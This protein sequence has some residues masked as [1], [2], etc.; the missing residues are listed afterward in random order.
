MLFTL[1]FNFKNIHTQPAVVC[2]SQKLVLLQYMSIM[3]IL[4]NV[5]HS[6][7]NLPSLSQSGAHVAR[8]GSGSLTGDGM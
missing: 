4:N 2:Q 5:K 8:I 1:Q 6:Y 7:M 3:S